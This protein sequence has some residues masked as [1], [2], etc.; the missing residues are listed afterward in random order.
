MANSGEVQQVTAYTTISSAKTS[1]VGKA[2]ATVLYLQNGGTTKNQSSW[3]NF[4][5]PVPIN[6][7]VQSAFLKVTLNAAWVGG[8]NLIIRRVTKTGGWSPGVINW[9]NRPIEPLGISTIDAISIPSS[10]FPALTK[11][12]VITID[13]TNHIRQVAASQPWYGWEISTSSVSVNSLVGSKTAV[14]LNATFAATPSK[15]LSTRPGTASATP[16]YIST[17]I[18]DLIIDTNVA[19]SGI[20]SDAMEIQLSNSSSV[21]ATGAFTSVVYPSPT[22]LTS[23]KTAVLSNLS[24][25]PTAANN[26]GYWWIGRYRSAIGGLWSPWSS[27]IKYT[28]KDQGTLTI[29]YPADS[30]SNIVNDSTPPIAWSLTGQTQ[31]RYQLQIIDPAS[32]AVPRFDSGI[33]VSTAVE[34]TPTFGAINQTGKTYTVR[35]STKDTVDRQDASVNGT[36]YPIYK[37]V[38]KNFTYVL[39]NLT[40]PVSALQIT[41]QSPKPYVK[42]AWTRPLEPDAFIIVRDG[43]QVRRITSGDYTKIG[44]SYTYNDNFPPAQVQHT[45]EVQ[46]VVD[47]IVSTNNPTGVATNRTSLAWIADVENNIYVGIT[48]EA[49]VTVNLTEQGTTFKLLGSPFDVHITGSLGG[50][51]GS[52]S[53]KLCGEC[54]GDGT[55]SDQLQADILTLRNNPDEVAKILYLAIG[56][57]AI[58]VNI[59]DVSTFPLYGTEFGKTYGVTFNFHEV[60]P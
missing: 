44:T 32:S 31:E 60:A 35:L 21:G 42:L 5:T 34:R 53:G 45:Y 57:I 47:N 22:I 9:A 56:N 54:I 30:P 18:P 4:T 19:E 50:Y 24:G 59:Y 20:M 43:V 12:T 36:P 29:T 46:A 51:S 48:G 17:G 26:A 2:N 58:P 23:T 38:S 8:G 39:S 33:V 11:G 6:N 55:T 49:P 7:I 41:D 10:A 52:V 15:P 37:T 14:T 25:A 16:M 40:D 28:R 1:T 3:I 13:V 27:P